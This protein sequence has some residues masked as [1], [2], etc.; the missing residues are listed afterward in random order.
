MTE[1]QSACQ[2]CRLADHYREQPDEPI[3]TLT[4]D[5]G[6][7][8]HIVYHTNRRGESVVNGRILSHPRYGESAWDRFG[9]SP[10]W[11]EEY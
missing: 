9:D 11:A 2:R 10:E 4:R 3:R 6:D 8:P 1:P 5:T 7:W